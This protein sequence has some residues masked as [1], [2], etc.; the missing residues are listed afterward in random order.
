[1][2]G[3][4]TLLSE[5]PDV[6]QQVETDMTLFFRGLA[7]VP[8]R[9]AVDDISLMAPIVEA[10]YDP[11]AM[12]AAPRAR[13]VTWLRQYGDRVRQDGV[14]DAQRRAA[15][16]RVNPKYVLRNYLAQQAIDALAAGDAST[17]NRLMKVLQHPYEEQPDHNELSARRPEWAR[18]KAG[19]SALSCSS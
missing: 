15:M 17:L 13:L 4:E 1:M 9:E 6:L 19:C 3:D 5:L 18:H 11:A 8:V 14:P 12:T 10:F 2:P 16:N 7:N